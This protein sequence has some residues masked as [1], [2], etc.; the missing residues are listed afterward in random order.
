MNLI[1]MMKRKRI[2]TITGS[3]SQSKSLNRHRNLYSACAKFA[4]FKDN[5][6]GPLQCTFSYFFLVPVLTGSGFSFMTVL[7]CS[8]PRCHFQRPKRWGRC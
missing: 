2:G 5:R 6:S 8:R 1:L 4:A 3:H 7:L